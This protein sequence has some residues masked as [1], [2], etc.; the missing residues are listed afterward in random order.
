MG[1]NL[2]ETTDLVTFTEGLFILFWLVYI[3][4]CLILMGM[5]VLSLALP[6][7]SHILQGT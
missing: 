2:K 6:P 7:I 3:A 1:S 5:Q 4:F